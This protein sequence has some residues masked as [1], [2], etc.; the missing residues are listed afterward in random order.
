M[1]F[2]LLV[3]LISLSLT[4]LAEDS[5][6]VIKVI[7]GNTLELANGETVRLIGIEATKEAYEFIKRRAQGKTI[8]LEFDQQQR[9]E[10]GRLL[11]YVYVKTRFNKARG[12]Y[13]EDDHRLIFLNAEVIK[14]GYA[15]PLPESINN[16]YSDLFQRKY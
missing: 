11:A 9:D 8:R 10:Q 12:D 6:L 7:D 2:L 5:A 15:R 4:A 3:T 13:D 1:K 14:K 16:K